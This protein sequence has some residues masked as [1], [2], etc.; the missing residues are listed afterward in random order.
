[1]ASNRGR[2]ASAGF[3]NQTSKRGATSSAPDASPSH[4]VN[5]IGQKFSHCARPAKQRLSGP[6]VALNKVLAPA[7]SM[8]NRKM[9]RARSKTRLPPANRRTRA[10][11]TTASSVFPT[12]IPSEGRAAP[13]AQRL[14]ANAPTK[15]PGQAQGPS[16]RSAA[17]EIPVGGHRGVALGCTY[18]R[19][20]P[21]LGRA[22]VYR[23]ESRVDR[24]PR[25]DP[26][27]H[28]STDSIHVGHRIG[29]R[30]ARGEE[31]HNSSHKTTTGGVGGRPPSLKTR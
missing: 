12:A 4:H 24:Q 5:Q 25:G 9:S 3:W 19:E 22:D 27:R 17:I 21:V 30:S 26:L 1:M 14:A 31:R 29:A 11:A 8:A 28:G 23:G 16:R 7:A 6:I 18:A 20:S 10:A 2:R 15:I 13:D